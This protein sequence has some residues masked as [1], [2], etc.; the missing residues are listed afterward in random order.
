[1]TQNSNIRIAQINLGRKKELTDIL[2]NS[3]VKRIDIIMV[4]EPWYSPTFEQTH[5]SYQALWPATKGKRPRVLAWVSK[6]RRDLRV[7]QVNSIFDEAD[8]QGD[9]LVLKV[10]QEQFAPFHLINVY[11]EGSLIDP[12]KEFTLSRIHHSFDRIPPRTIVLGDM[13]AHDVLWNSSAQVNLRSKEIK[14]LLE[15]GRFH[16]LN[17]PDQATFGVARSLKNPSVIDLTLVT[18]DLVPNIED[19]CVAENDNPG[20][21]HELIVFAVNLGQIRQDQAQRDSRPLLWRDADWELFRKAFDIIAPQFTESLNSIMEDVTF[22]WDTRHTDPNHRREDIEQLLDEAVQILSD[23]IQASAKASLRR[24]SDIPKAKRWWTKEIQDAHKDLNRLK[25]CAGRSHLG[26]DVRRYRSGRKEF[27]KTVLKA[28][29]EAWNTFLEGLQGP[30]VFKIYQYL[31][32]KTSKKIQAMVKDGKKY[33][34]F[35]E[36]ESILTSTLFP[37]STDNNG[38]T[39][40]ETDEAFTRRTAIRLR[41]DLC[42]QQDSPMFR[43]GALESQNSKDI[44]MP[45]LTFTEFR[46]AAFSMAPHKAAGPDEIPAVALQKCFDIFGEPMYKICKACLIVGYHP[47][48]WKIALVAIIPKPNKPDYSKPNTNRPISLLSCLGKVLERIVASRLTYWSEAHQLLHPSQYGC[49]TARSC[50]DAMV[51]LQ[52]NV[53]TS[54]G[55]GQCASSLMMDVKG[56]FNAVNPRRLIDILIQMGLPNQLIDWVRSFLKDRKIKL[57]FDGQVGKSSDIDVGVPQGSPTSPPLFNLYMSPLF[58]QLD[59]LSF[60][61]PSNYFPSSY[62]DDI[63]IG[64]ATSSY[65]NNIRHLRAVYNYIISWGKRYG[66]SFDDEKIELMHWAS[67]AKDTRDADI[68]LPLELDHNTFHPHATVKVLGFTI[69]P[70]MTFTQHVAI[71]TAKASKAWNAIAAH[72]RSNGGI[73]PT[74]IRLLYQACV[75]PIAFYGSCVYHRPTKQNP[76]RKLDIIQNKAL[77]SILAAVKWTPVFPLQVEASLPPIKVQLNDIN[78]RESIRWAALP[79]THPIRVLIAKSNARAYKE[80]QISK[81]LYTTSEEVQ[82]RTERFDYEVCTPWEPVETFSTLQNSPTSQPRVVTRLTSINRIEATKAHLDYI[83]EVAQDP[84]KYKTILLYT[85]ASI[86]KVGGH[87]K[88]QGAVAHTFID[89]RKGSRRHRT[90]SDPSLAVLSDYSS[91]LWALRKG[92]EGFHQYCQSTN[93]LDTTSLEIFIDNQSA[94]ETCLSK[95]PTT[96]QHIRLDIQEILKRILLQYPDLSVTISW[97]PGHSTIFGNETCD[98]AAKA[99][100]RVSSSFHIDKANHSIFPI[101]QAWRKEQRREAMLNDWKTHHDDLKSKSEAQTSQSDPSGRLSHGLGTEYQ[102]VFQAIGKFTTHPKRWTQN[103]RHTIT[104][105][106]QAIT[107]KGFFGSGYRTSSDIPKKAYKYCPHCT[108]RTETIQHIIE[109]CPKYKTDRKDL[110]KPIKKGASLTDV[111]KAKR[112]Y[113]ILANYLTETKTCNSKYFFERI[114]KWKLKNPSQPT[115]HATSSSQPICIPGSAS[116][117]RVTEE[118]A[119]IQQDVGPLQSA[120][121]KYFPIFNMRSR[122][123]TA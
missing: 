86:V 39:P 102:K 5:P 77:R 27:I 115:G 46:N 56:A 10:H 58:R 1:M 51:V 67:H 55:R 57:V 76:Y 69:D 74:A 12:M 75:L 89:F 61:G 48:Q 80:T 107:G 117:L 31:K 34:T 64:I 7:D 101:S 9:V 26:T 96:A 40:D 109:R 15:D 78:R 32:P 30:E 110:L 43:P 25:R 73:C 82:R 92:L 54:Q 71:Q 8:A 42:L 6:H 19:W 59:R 81:I 108:N 37:K 3:L 93:L 98:A 104:L 68:Q 22:L 13:N 118:S 87:V 121:L 84:Q 70:K 85:D 62:V 14:S 99:R 90:V 50:S 11:N 106:T 36:K 49:R 35:E 112:G 119:P 38:S 79:H 116:Q 60:L 17:E 20:S 122:G 65:E 94:I 103:P 111:L 120:T 47:S 72:T 21:D 113:A 18:T 105:L 33:E 123:R 100:A 114:E 41:T 91:E 44:P 23:A 83:T 24:R 29:K 66:I 53:K 4:Q 28:K 2:L 63:Q 95:A 16:L 88:A 52:Y 97:V 45:T